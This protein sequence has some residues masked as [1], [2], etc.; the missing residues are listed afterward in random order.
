MLHLLTLSSV[1][2]QEK[3]VIFINKPIKRVW[4]PSRVLR[5]DNTWC[6]FQGGSSSCGVSKV[7]WAYTCFFFF[8]FLTYLNDV[9]FS[10]KFTL[11]AVNKMW[12]L[13]YDNSSSHFWEPF[14]SIWFQI[15][16]IQLYFVEHLLLINFANRLIRGFRRY[17]PI[18]VK[19]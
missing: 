14:G 4:S 1:T 7:I 8:L 10:F 9:I 11:L 2:S 13:Y 17:L 5:H 6:L 12:S 15:K 16:F 18:C 3:K 19:S